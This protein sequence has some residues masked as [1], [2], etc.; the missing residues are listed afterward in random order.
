M[1]ALLTHRFFLKAAEPPDAPQTVHLR[2]ILDRCKAELATGVK[3]TPAEWNPARGRT[4]R[5]RFANELLDAWK[6]RVLALK[7]TDLLKGQLRTASQIKQALLDNKQ[8][9]PKAVAYLQRHVDRMAERSNEYAKGSLTPYQSTV[10]WF[11]EFLESRRSA[12]LPLSQLSRALCLDF[13]H[14]LLTTPLPNAD[15]PMLRNVASKHLSRLRTM[16]NVAVREELIEKNPMSGI[17]LK[18]ER[19]N[20][21][22]LTVEELGRL[23]A[24]DLRAQASLDRVRDLFVFSVY[25]GLRYKDALSLSPA[26]LSTDGEGR[27]WLSLVHHKTGD[28]VKLPLLQ[29]AQRVLEKYAEL[30]EL[31]GKLLPSLSNQKLNAYLKVLADLAG[32]MRPLTH[33]V[34]RHTFATTI[35]LSKGVPIE[36]VSKLLGHRNLA[37]TQIY[38]KI[39]SDYLGQVAK[40]LDAELA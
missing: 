23:E 35:T 30:P 2:L 22:C 29:P 25:T 7:H 20:R 12:Q 4:Q 33:H 38:A 5:N 21:E 19:T 6:A 26:Q 1:S 11:A 37:T 24:L 34:A 39:T 40:R 10:R 32:I 27:Q 17:R 16:L 36:V 9:G 28:A 18:Q 14:Y 3:V 15:R 31:T 8:S 13:E